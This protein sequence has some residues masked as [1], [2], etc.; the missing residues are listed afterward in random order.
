[1]AVNVRALRRRAPEGE[2]L[3]RYGEMARILTGHPGA[4]AE[5]GITWVKELC[6]ALSVPSLS[7]FGVTEA[8]FPALIEKGAVASSMQANPIKL[9]MDELREILALAL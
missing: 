4:T 3:C 8:D 5:D 1:M 9:T 7:T 2:A 6:S